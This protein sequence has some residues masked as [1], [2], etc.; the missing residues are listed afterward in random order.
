[1][2]ESGEKANEISKQQFNDNN[3]TAVVNAHAPT[4]VIM[5][6]M[7]NRKTLSIIIVLV[8]TRIATAAADKPPAEG[9]VLWLDATDV[10]TLKLD[11]DS[12]AEWK[13][14]VGEQIPTVLKGDMPTLIRQGLNGKPVLRFAGHSGLATT[15]AIRST[16]GPATV[17]VVFQRSAEQMTKSHWQRLVSSQ[18]DRKEKDNVTPNFCVTSEHDGEPRPTEAVIVHQE[19]GG[20]VIGLLSIGRSVGGY[21]ALTGDIAEVLIYDRGFL[22]EG[23]QRQA[24][25]YLH[26]KWN[27]KITETGWTRNGELGA[28]PAHVHQDLPLSDQANSGHWKL[29]AEL[30]DEFNSA[31]LDLKKWHLDPTGPG[32]WWGREPAMFRPSNVT[33]KDGML[34]IAFRK[35]DVPEMKQHKGYAGYT[36]ALMQST[37]RT[38]YGYYEIRARPMN[39]AGSSAFWFHNTGLKDNGTEIDVFE[40]GAKAKGFERKYN[41]N[42]HVWKTPTENRHWSVGGVWNAPWDLGADF[43]VYGFDWSKDSLTWYVDGVEVRHARNTNWFYPMRVVFD[44]EAMWQWFGKVDDADLPSTFDVDYLRVWRRGDVK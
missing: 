27:A 21:S 12:V 4:H 19:F 33:Q 44:S 23:D 30:S 20:S 39:S 36:S 31:E 2:I 10:S 40:I 17:F 37:A 41:M 32:D 1:M 6:V 18:L 43:H 11:G 42:A 7:L 34:H 3:W 5:P 9:L 22:S 8:L 35:E 15:G 38:L 26:E 13:S 28:V 25:D 14:K 29:D 24:L 16:P